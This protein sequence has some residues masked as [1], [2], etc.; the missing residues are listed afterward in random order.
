MFLTKKVSFPLLAA[1]CDN[2]PHGKSP[3][4]RLSLFC[5]SEM[6]RS[7]VL[8]A[9]SAWEFTSPWLHTRRLMFSVLGDEIMSWLVIFFLVN[10]IPETASAFPAQKVLTAECMTIGDEV[11]A[12]LNFAFPE[13]EGLVTCIAIPNLGDRPA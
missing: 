1:F 4:F 2:P 8:A 12:R 10:G 9:G 11:T 5:T 6:R 3:R 13:L 7:G